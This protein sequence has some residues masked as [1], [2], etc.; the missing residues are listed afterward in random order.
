[1]KNLSTAF[2]LAVIAAL[3]SACAEQTPTRPDREEGTAPANEPL[4]F[5]RAG[6]S[7]RDRFIV[8]FH[9]TT[10][11]APALAAR[12]V[13]MYGGTLHYTYRSALR[14]F[15]ATL[16]PSAV[17]ALRRNPA[18]AWVEQDEIVSANYTQ[19]NPTWGLDRIDQPS[20]PLDKTFTYDRDGYGVRIY[21]L[22]TGILYSHTKFESRAVFGF[23]AY[24]GTGADCNGHGT[25]VAGTAAG[26]T[27]GVAQR[28]TLVSVRVLDCSGN[29]AASAVIAGVD[30]VTQH[31]VKPAVAN[32]SLGGA[33]NTSLDAAVANSIAAGVTYAIAAGNSNADACNYS[34]ARVP[35]AL[36]VGATTSVD[37][38][39]SFSNWGSCVD[40]FA[41][42]SAITSTW[43]T[44]TTA[45]MTLDGTSMASPHVAGAAATYLQQY[46][47]A[48]PAAVATAIKNYAYSGKLTGIGTGSPNRLLNSVLDALH[49]RVSCPVDTGSCFASAS[50][51][52]GTGYSFT[53]NQATETSDANGF[54]TADVNGPCLNNIVSVNVQLTDSGGGH[55]SATARVNC[56]F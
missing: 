21:V 19:F 55:A 10:Q 39:S 1:M 40:V 49:V 32:M 45:T 46:P 30:W 2:A 3:A 56:S 15:A 13:T 12:L 25:H 26:Y 38:R 34:P 22:D 5:E 33:G 17:E 8:V 29:G 51:G 52:T 16:P 7:I 18:V 43:Y 9:D 11:D 37:A 47:T 36:T 50:G 54:S 27:Y 35:A 31:H 28:A 53:W 44:S 14:G 20:L 48:T 6:N 41:P 42:G 23:D 4:R 24:G